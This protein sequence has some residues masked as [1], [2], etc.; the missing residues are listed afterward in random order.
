[1]QPMVSQIQFNSSSSS[2]QNLFPSGVISQNEIII[3]AA[4]QPEALECFWMPPFPSILLTWCVYHL[5]YV[6]MSTATNIMVII[7]HLCHYT[8]LL[9][10]L[11]N[12]FVYCHCWFVKDANSVILDPSKLWL[13][14]LVQDSLAKVYKCH[15]LTSAYYCSPPLP[16]LCHVRQLFCTFSLLRMCP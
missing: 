14:C 9:V 3:N 5:F 16:S 4:A 7:S 6:P 10:L 8:S 13:S 15:D 1:M 2:L 11:L 12:P